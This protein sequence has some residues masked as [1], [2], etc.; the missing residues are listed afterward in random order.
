VEFL[1]GKEKT[2]NSELLQISSVQVKPSQ[3]LI[4]CCCLDL[5]LSRGIS[6][7]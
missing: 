1:L 4:L 3:A 2:L 6:T 5:L 7:W